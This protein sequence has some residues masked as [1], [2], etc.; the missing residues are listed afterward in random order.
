MTLFGII[1]SFMLV[2]SLRPKRTLVGELLEDVLSDVARRE[3]SK[4]RAESQTVKEE[5]PDDTRAR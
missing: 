5:T 4:R 1:V 3:M 2:S